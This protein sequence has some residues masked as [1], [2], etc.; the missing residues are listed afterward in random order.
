MTKYQRRQSSSQHTLA[1]LGSVLVA[2]I[3]WPMHSSAN[4]DGNSN[5]S[6]NNN[7]NGDTLTNDSGLAGDRESLNKQPR[8]RGAEQP[9]SKR[10]D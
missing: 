4:N 3:S 8:G 2:S 5:N 1:R 7:Y 6:T 9:S 10:V